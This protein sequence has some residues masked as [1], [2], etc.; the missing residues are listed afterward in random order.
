MSEMLRDNL[1]CQTIAFA[2]HGPRVTVVYRRI[3]ACDAFV[4]RVGR[5]VPKAVRHHSHGTCDTAALAYAVE[6]GLPGFQ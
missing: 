2:I 4:D 1:P 3:D 5:L 6:M